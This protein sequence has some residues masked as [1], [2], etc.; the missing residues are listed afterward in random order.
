MIFSRWIPPADV[1][2][3]GNQ[4]LVRLELAGISPD[5]I[6]IVTRGELLRVR[7]RRR[8]LYLQ[9]GFACHS[10]EISYSNFERDLEFPARIRP[11]SISLDYRDG[12]LLIHLETIDR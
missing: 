11:D 1:F 12:I 6:D 4:W 5:E 10:M 9:E 2:Y 8:D 7:G 3:S